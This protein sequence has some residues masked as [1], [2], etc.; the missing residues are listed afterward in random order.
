T[1]QDIK[2]VHYQARLLGV[3]MEEVVIHDFPQYYKVDDANMALNPVGLY[4]RKLEV[5]SLLL[6]AK[7]TL[8]KNITKAI[9]QAGFDVMELVL[10][11]IASADVA[12]SAD[13]K[14][15]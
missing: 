14:R 12:L 13:Q 4:A 8:I 7:N 6:V 15:D 1:S 11:S 2:K 5:Q 9:N 10:S 3:N